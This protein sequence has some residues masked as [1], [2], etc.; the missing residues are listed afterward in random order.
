MDFFEKLVKDLNVY[1]KIC[2]SKVILSSNLD[3]DDVYQD[4]TIKMWKVYSKHKEYFDKEKEITY[5]KYFKTV[6]FNEYKNIVNAQFAHKRS[7]YKDSYVDVYQEE[8]SFNNSESFEKEL[9]LKLSYEDIIF[10]VESKTVKKYLKVAQELKLGTIKEISE[11]FN[12]SFQSVWNVFR[13]EFQ[14]NPDLL[15]FNNLN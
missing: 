15:S 11:Y 10:N 12:K 6:I 2:C 13:R 14:N 7:I 3:F 1:L 9:I 4:L 8:Y 5:I